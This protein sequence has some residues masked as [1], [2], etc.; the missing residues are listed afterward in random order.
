MDLLTALRMQ[1]LTSPPRLAL[2][3]AGGKT[4]AMFTLARQL[5]GQYPT[6]LVAATTHL[7]QEQGK[8]ATSHDTVR[9]MEEVGRLVLRPGVQLVT[10]LLVGSPGDP[11]SRLAGLEEPLLQRLLEI[12][13][14][15]TIPLLVEADGARR[16]PLKAP[17]SHEPAIPGFV[18]RVIVVAGLLGLGQPL[19]W[20]TVHRPERFSELSGLGPGQPITAQ[21]VAAVLSHPEGGLKNIPPGAQRIL[22]LNQAEDYFRRMK[23]GSIIG[24]L[25]HHYSPVIVA[26][27]GQP[28]SPVYTVHEA[29]AGIVLA[30]GAGRRFDD[31][32]SANRLF[33]G[34]GDA[35]NFT[36]SK[37]LLEFHGEPL[38]RRAARLAVDAGLKPV[39]VVLGAYAAEVE[40]ALQG[41]SVEVIFNPDWESGQSTSVKAGLK[42]LPASTGAA[43]FL[44]G[45]QPYIGYDL[46]R[47]LRSKH[48]ATLAPLIAPLCNGQRA[49][50]AVFDRRTF[51]DLLALT[52]DVGG[53]A[54]FNMPERYTP[55]WLPWL[56]SH[57]L[58]DIDTPEDYNRLLE[59][60]GS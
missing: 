49:N 10:G 26:A 21:A 29:I 44:L 15:K 42:D 18:D 57:L 6:V 23:T 14:E 54:L 8:M 34:K 12:A 31:F 43:M 40:Q 11:R 22:L 50:P 60:E 13:I 47:E 56:D 35:R 3:G 1:N 30:A 17:E 20:L 48:A 5:L 24:D 4:T 2:V 38:V 46:I 32:R 39:R 52:G 9:S 51:P 45:D 36:F 16:L 25:M 33:A 53:R 59:M 41:L 58:M 19:D 37:M 28:G 7:A 27:L 55:A